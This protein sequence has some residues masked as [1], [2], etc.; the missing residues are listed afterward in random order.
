MRYAFGLRMSHGYHKVIEKSIYTLIFYHAIIWMKCF[1]YFSALK[2][3]WNL[4]R[5]DFNGI[6][7][8]TENNFTEYAPLPTFGIQVVIHSNN[9]LQRYTELDY[10]SV[11]PNEGVSVKYSQIN[12]ELVLGGFE[13]NCAE[14]DIREKQNSN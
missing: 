11:K 8:R 3:Y 14:Y 1:T 12:T 10:F 6:H 4:F 13:S 9:V 7:L 5:I 2:E